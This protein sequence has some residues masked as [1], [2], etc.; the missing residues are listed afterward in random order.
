M[1]GASSFRYQEM[2][3]EKLAECLQDTECVAIEPRSYS[4]ERDYYAPL[5]QF[6]KSRLMEV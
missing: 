1:A 4:D 2:V 3:S 5:R 6:L